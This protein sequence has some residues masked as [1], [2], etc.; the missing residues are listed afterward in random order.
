[1][2]A[3]NSEKLYHI[4]A[5]NNCI[6]HCLTRE[7]FEKVWDMIDKFLSVTATLHKDHI[8]YEE[9]TVKKDISIN[10]SY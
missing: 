8:S 6:Y 2:T 3:E 5:K 1:M 7:E 10:S 4:Y 9:V